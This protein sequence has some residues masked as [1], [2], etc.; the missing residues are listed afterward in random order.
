[1]SKG[2]S[3]RSTTTTISNPVIPQYVQSLQEEAFEAARQFQPEVFSGDR[4]APQNPFETQQI[5]ALGQFGT[6]TGA[7]DQFRDA[8]SG[9]A[10]GNV[11]A[12]D[13]LQQE[14][15]REISSD[16]LNRVIDDR[17]ADTTNRLTSQFSRAGRLGSDAFGTALG[18]GIGTAVAPI[19]AQ[20][21]IAEARRRASLANT[22]ANAERQAAALQLSAAGQLPRAQ[23]LDLQRIAGLGSAGELQRAMDT[24]PIVAEQQ[25]IAEQTEAD[26]QSLNA[27]LSA[28]GAGTVGIGTTTQQVAPPAGIAQTL[29]GLGLIASGLG[30][31]TGLLGF[32]PGLN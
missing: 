28:A 23:A 5:E 11:G 10:L 32:I 26:R 3:G 4:F 7:I 18:R 13:L 12:P 31:N 8:I 21:E 1:M 19:L 9:I 20:N 27:L 15:D 24:R 17:L 16:F 2:S 30:G 25:R 29:S 14:Y 22:I 6:D